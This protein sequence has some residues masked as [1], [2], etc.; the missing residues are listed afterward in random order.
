[1]HA[2]NDPT[3]GRVGVGE[4]HKKNKLALRE[5]RGVGV[6]VVCAKFGGGSLPD[7]EVTEGFVL[8]PAL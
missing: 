3:G 1:M 7:G 5:A 8:T 6:L 2:G 4:K